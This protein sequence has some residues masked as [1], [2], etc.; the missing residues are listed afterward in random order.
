MSW[1]KPTGLLAYWLIG[2][3]IV[4]EIQNSEQRANYGDQVITNVSKALTAAF[5]KGFSERNVWQYRQFYQ[6]FP[7]FPIRR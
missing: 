2:R 3:R 7:K 1:L 5:G 6:M 4:E